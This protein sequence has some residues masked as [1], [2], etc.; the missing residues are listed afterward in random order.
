[1]SNQTIETNS[2][3]FKSVLTALPLGFLERE[4]ERRQNFKIDSQIHSFTKINPRHSNMIFS[5]IASSLFSKF[6]S[7]R[8]ILLFVILYTQKDKL[9]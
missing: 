6:L 8:K 4:R 9:L 2:M 1:M 5:M 7:L 3:P